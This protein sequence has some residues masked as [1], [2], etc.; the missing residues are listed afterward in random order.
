MPASQRPSGIGT[1]RERPLHASL[2]RWYA[3]PGDREEVPVDGF[4]VDLV[5]GD[6]LIEIQTRGFAGMKPKVTSLL[7]AG[8]RLRVVH[9]IAVDRWIVNVDAN[10]AR[11][12]RR[13]SPRHGTLS[14][15][16][17]ELV[18]FPDLL[19]H[20]GFEIEV[21]LTTE[22]ELR[23]NVPGTCWRRRGWSVLERRL[24]DVLDRVTLARP[25]DVACLLPAG[26]PDRFTTADLAARLGRPRFEA[27]RLAYCLRAAGVIEATGKRG[28]S[29]EY[30]EAGDPR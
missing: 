7:A 10:G 25:R 16:A 19:S 26:L 14:D 17:T 5:R 30:A 2:K 1:L 11:L 12:G 3:R 13:R 8:H 24:I 15:L 22:E 9:P 18:T 27:Q 23:S 21:L 4:V 6:L 20:P 28:G 29:I